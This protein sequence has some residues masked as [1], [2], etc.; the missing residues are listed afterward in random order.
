MITSIAIESILP[1][2]AIV[3]CLINGFY[4]CL[5]RAGASIFIDSVLLK[6]TIAIHVRERV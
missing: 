6:A 1:S 3:K 5:N 2:I 4:S